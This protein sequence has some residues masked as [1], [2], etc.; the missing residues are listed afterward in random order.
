MRNNFLKIFKH[1]K[2]DQF[3]LIVVIMSLLILVFGSLSINFFII[4]FIVVIFNLIW[5]IPFIKNNNF[6][7][8]RIESS[9]NMAK[10]KKLKTK[11]PKNTNIKNTKKSKPKNNSKNKKIGKIVLLSALGFFLLC[12][13]IGIIFL[14]YIVVS[15]DKFDPN[16]LYTK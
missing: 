5:I 15:A 6:I 8:E 1:I 9:D 13:I 2:D 14:V 7:K 4:L 11:V 10:V 3:N 12:M 16:K